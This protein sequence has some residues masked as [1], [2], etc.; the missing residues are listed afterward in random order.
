ML[1]KYRTLIGNCAS[2][3]DCKHQCAAL[4]SCFGTCWLW[5]PKAEKLCRTSC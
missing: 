5:P 1:G 3:I 4:K 2:Q